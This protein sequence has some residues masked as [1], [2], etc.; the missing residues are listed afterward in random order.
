MKTLEGEDFLST[1]TSH[2]PTHKDK[3][4]K[5]ER[6]GMELQFNSANMD[7]CEDWQT[8]APNLKKRAFVSSFSNEKKHKLQ[9][10]E[11][12]KSFLE[13]KKIEKMNL[14]NSNEKCAKE[15]EVLQQKIARL[16]EIH[17]S[18]R[19]K[20]FFGRNLSQKSTKKLKEQAI[21]YR[22]VVGKCKDTMGSFKPRTWEQDSSLLE[23]ETSLGVQCVLGIA[24]STVIG[25]T[26]PW[27]RVTRVHD[28]NC[29]P[30]LKEKEFRI[31]KVFL[32]VGSNPM[33][34]KRYVARF[35]SW[36]IPVKFSKDLLKL[37]QVH[38]IVSFA[39]K[40]V[41]SL[42]EIDH[43]FS[44]SKRVS[45]NNN[46]DFRAPNVVCRIGDHKEAFLMGL[47]ERTRTFKRFLFSK[48]IIDSSCEKRPHYFEESMDGYIM[49]LKVLSENYHFD[50]R[51]KIEQVETEPGLVSYVIVPSENNPDCCDIS[52]FKSIAINQPENLTAHFFDPKDDC[53]C[54][55]FKEY[56]EFCALCKSAGRIF[57][58]LAEQNN[59]AI[60]K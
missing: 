51:T 59:Q 38:K 23:E 41:G 1:F 5:P 12:A 25:K 7:F 47:S 54:S 55:T 4:P 52:I 9:R 24:F 16:K 11:S 14:I 57:D 20:S 46:L 56:P 22:H 43:I 37:G 3:W 27:N 45:S 36:N 21:R 18:L 32:P 49:S 33:T 2:E 6:K 44:T 19:G 40:N 48:D 39:R 15:N 30:F 28:C 50:T 8:L 35:D 34:A 42:F 53:S 58:L 29:V 26:I 31:S 13:R 60:D 10:V 17:S